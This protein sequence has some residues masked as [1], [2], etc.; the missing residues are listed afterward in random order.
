MV[1]EPLSLI[2][3]VGILV[4]RH[5]DSTMRVKW[6]EHSGGLSTPDREIRPKPV[7]VIR[8]AASPPAYDG[9]YKF[10]N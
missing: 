1:V 10:C 6:N 9:I 5:L 4:R 3:G 8:F 7:F 2:R